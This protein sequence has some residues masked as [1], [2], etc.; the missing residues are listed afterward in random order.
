MTRILTATLGYPRIGE[1]REW[2][3]WL[4]QYWSG[5]MGEHELLAN[6]AALRLKGLAAQRKAGID[7]IASGDFSLYDHMLDA[8]CMFGLVPGRFPYAGGPVSTALYFAMARGTETAAACRKADWFGTGYYHVVPEL[9]EREPVL[10]ENRPLAAYLEAK[11]S[12]GLET[13]PVLTGPYT[14]VKLAERKDGG[15]LENWIGRLAPLYGQALRELAAAGAAWVQLSEP[16]LSRDMPEN[17]L[18][19]VEAAYAAIRRAAPAIRIMLQ[20]PYGPAAHYGRLIR[21]PVNGIGLDFVHGRENNLAAVL[22]LGVPAGWRL[23]VGLIDGQGVWRTDLQ[24][25]VFLVKTLARALG[26]ACELALQPSCS[27]QHVPVSLAGESGLAPHVKAILAFADEKL[28][29]LVTLKRALNRVGTVT[30]A[31]EEKIHESAVAVRNRPLYA[32]RGLSVESGW[33]QTMGADCM[34][35]R[36]S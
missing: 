28:D 13:A 33:V 26:G 15:S 34:R 12:L 22:S 24:E 18:A 10:A 6:M 16:A 17:E 14:F 9:G 23:G 25:A 21:L 32:K 30:L 36:I 19:A 7:W 20:I 11:R 31:A 5:T 35:K 3:T 8:A 1:N 2:S 29:E 4:A 27:L